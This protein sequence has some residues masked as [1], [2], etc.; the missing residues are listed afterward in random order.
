MEVIRRELTR[1]PVD[2]TWVHEMDGIAPDEFDLVVT[3]GGD[4]T[5]LHASHAIGPTPVLGI[6]SAPGTSV[7]Y[8]T[9][10]AAGQAGELFGRA[11]EGSLPIQRLNRMEVR[12]DGRVVT[13]RALNDVLFC[14]ECP[15][16]T[17]RYEIRL[18]GRAEQQMSSGIWIAT[19]AGSTAAIRAA[20]GRVMRAGSR[21]L[22][23]VVREPFPWGGADQ[24]SAPE[25]VSGFVASG[26]VLE[27]HSR[28]TTARL[29]VD[30]PH[31]VFPVG[32][33][34]LVSFGRSAEPLNLLGYRHQKSS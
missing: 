22:Q 31:V 9:A 20:G 18:D 32:F 23:F 27:I 13:N 1:L 15:A 33:G 19:A 6:N 30:G 12:V 3:V 2:A 8:L 26:R 7:G 17:S 14:H 21:R 16:T 4:G 25:I 11:V 29:Y 5:V 24:P 34:D 10:G 28:S